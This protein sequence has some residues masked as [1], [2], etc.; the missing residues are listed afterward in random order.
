[1]RQMVCVIGFLA[2]AVTACGTGNE[3]APRSLT[4]CFPDLEGWTRDGDT[5]IYTPETLFD[6]INGG[7]DLYLAYDFEELATQS[8]D[9]GPD[10]SITVDIYR[11]GTPNDGFGI[12]S[13]EKSPESTFLPVGAQGYYDKGVLNFFKGRYYVKI[14][15]FGIGTDEVHV[16]S[17]LAGTIADKLDGTVEMPRVLDCLPDKAKLG[18]SERYIAQDFLGHSFLH[19]AFVADYEVLRG[20]RAIP[21]QM[22]IIEAADEAG[23]REMIAKYREHAKTDPPPEWDT[24][25]LIR[26]SD[27]YYASKGMLNMMTRG[28]YIWGLF[29]DDP[30]VYMTYLQ[31]TETLLAKA[32]LI[33]F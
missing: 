24:T 31:E 27:P 12:Y 30:A 1:M 8:Y 16:L 26:L 15:A 3:A 23:A 20:N 13:Q 7:A 5:E 33:E 14:M 22:F 32:G 17:P 11:H 29:G 2:L 9:S 6:Y 28:C 4:D 10:R 19:S 18:R 21:F 25:K